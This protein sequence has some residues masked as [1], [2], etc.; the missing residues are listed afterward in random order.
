M[1]LSLHSVQREI[2]VYNY[3]VLLYDYRGNLLVERVP[4]I[5]F[6]TQVPKM[7]MPVQDEEDEMGR[8]CR[9]RGRD[10]KSV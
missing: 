2:N 6:S 8:A 3:V 1:L 9:T 10:E 5:L 4:Q 7:V